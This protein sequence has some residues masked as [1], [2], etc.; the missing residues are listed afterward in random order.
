[1]RYNNKMLKKVAFMALLSFACS[2]TNT[3]KMDVNVL[4]IPVQVE[5]HNGTLKLDEG[6]QIVLNSLPIESLGEQTQ[7]FI[8]KHTGLDLKI[9]KGNSEGSDKSIRFGIA[10]NADYGEEGYSLDIDENGVSI[11]AENTKGLFYGAQSLRQLLPVSASDKVELP[12]VHIL[13]YPRFEWR[14]LHLDVSRHFFTVD[15]V[16]RFIDLM[17]M[18]KLNTFH[19]HLTDDQGWRIEIKKYPLLTQKGAW[20]ERVGFDFNQEKGLNVDDGKPYGGFYTQEDIKEVVRYAKMH[21]ITVVPEIDIPGHS[22]AAIHAYPYLSCFPK[23]AAPVRLTGGVSDGVYC[24]GKESSF[25]FIKDVLDEVMALFPSHRIHIGGDEAPKNNWKRCPLCQKRIRQE[26]L[27]DEHELQSYFIGRIADYLES[28]GRQLIGWDE[29]MEGNSVDGATIMSWRG[30]IPG[31]EAARAGHEVIMT[32]LIYTY[33]SRTQSINEVTKQSE[34]GDVLSMR[35]L[36]EY[37][38]VPDAIEEK[39]KQNIIGV[40]ACQWTEGTPNQKILEYKEYPRAIALAEMAWSPQDYREWEGFYQRLTKHLPFLSSYGVGYGAPSYDVAMQVLP[41]KEPGTVKLTFKTERKE[42][43]FYT[44]DG[45]E[46]TSTSNQT[47]DSLLLAQPA[48]VKV[49]QFR[50]DGSRGRIT[51]RDV[52]FHKGIA[53]KVTYTYPYSE[54]HAGGGDFGLVDGIVNQWQGFEKSDAEFVVDLGEVMSVS[55]IQTRWRYDIGDWVFRPLSVS[56]EVSADG[57]AYTKVYEQTAENPK[58]KYEKGIMDVNY[59]LADQSIRFIRVKAKS[60]KINPTWHKHA[61]GASWIF[62]D[63]VVVN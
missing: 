58:G 60:P 37:N 4:P 36:Y 14:G 15:E 25:T 12:Y 56:Y 30:V 5:Q 33:I 59:E 17:A 49:C 45:S 27:R 51:S 40:Q 47:M 53:K 31:L 18:Y 10:L 63:E 62:V 20:R 41:S 23:E 48:T 22:V 46:P 19:W 32:P 13:D 42:P 26:G 35:T 61:G 11:L 7:E 21:E 3:T 6:T 50:P 38:P 43:I 16:K 57:T 24:A 44:L 8:K 9:V 2:C 1:M 52:S 55:Q 54:V 39:Y 29:I 28:H 34:N